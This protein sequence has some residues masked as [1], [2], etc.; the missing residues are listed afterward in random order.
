MRPGRRPGPP[1]P[2]CGLGVG[3]HG[4]VGLSGGHSDQRP[5]GRVEGSTREGS[6]LDLVDPLGSRTGRAGVAHRSHA[7]PRRVASRTERRR[8]RGV[9][10]GGTS[11]GVATVA[12]L[13]SAA[14]S[15]G[16]EP[17]RPSS[18]TAS[19]RSA[20]GAVRCTSRIRRRSAATTAAHV[21]TFTSPDRGRGW[22]GVAGAAKVRTWSRILSRLARA[23]PVSQ[24]SRP[25]LPGGRRDV[26]LYRVG[27]G[28]GTC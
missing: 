21:E 13:G 20:I 7:P 4:H 28:L 18:R 25:A 26:W 14:T 23:H 12:I 19:A 10:R 9:T 1:A 17:S 16:I 15:G 24:S 8:G 27:G 11:R 6:S 2:T 3:C 5:R 22:L